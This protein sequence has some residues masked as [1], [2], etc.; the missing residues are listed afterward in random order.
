MAA[1]T[2]AQ[3]FSSS[4]ELDNSLMG[5]PSSGLNYN[6][7]VHP[8]VTISNLLAHLPVLPFTFSAYNALTSYNVF[9]ITKNKTDIVTY[10][11]KVWESI[12]AA[13]V[14]NT[15]A[16]GTKWRETN[17][18]SLKLR[19]FIWNVDANV[20][21]ELHLSRSLIENQLIYNVGKTE[22]LLSGDYIGWCIEPKNSDY[23]KIKINE[24]ALQA[25]TIDQVQMYVVNQGRVVDTITLNPSNGILSFEAVNYT[26]SG[27]GRFFFV[28]ANREV[29]SE[30]AYLDALRYDS[31]VVY[32]VTGTG[33]SPQSIE[34]TENAFSNGISLNI[35]TYLDTDDYIETNADTLAK[36]KQC[37]FEMDAIELFLNNPNA[38][39]N[40][41]ERNI[42]DRAGLLATEKLDSSMNT[43]SKKYQSELKSA[44]SAIEKTFDN[45]L[46]PR[47]T[48]IIKQDVI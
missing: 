47:K 45:F 38:N 29:L 3:D 31:F 23:V 28:I 2:F 6:R 26:I 16:T 33:T 17:I 48:I 37:R 15:P 5:V 34:Y 8:L 11:N 4:V 44:K 46:K 19:S 24:I 13:N 10:N 39:F 41:Q 35:S 22:R 14:G 36:F 42:V 32:P 30:S 18:E 43:V 12:S 7:G 25:T 20:K 40:G 9:E 27:K 1:L 21:S